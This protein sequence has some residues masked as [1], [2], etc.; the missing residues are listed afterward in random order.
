MKYCYYNFQFLYI[1]WL[2]TSIHMLIFNLH[3]YFSSFLQLSFKHTLYILDNIPMSDAFWNYFL[4]VC[5]ISYPLLHHPVLCLYL[6]IIFY[7]CA[8]LSVSKFPPFYK[9]T[10]SIRLT[11]TIKL[12]FILVTYVKTLSPNKVIFWGIKG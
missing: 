3:T 1:I 6:H 11:S 12:H 4:S 5:G 2:W 8:C 9:D 7:L 10:H